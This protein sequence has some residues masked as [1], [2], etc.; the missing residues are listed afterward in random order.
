MRRAFLW[1]NH[2]VGRCAKTAS[3]ASWLYA[4][5]SLFPRSV[6]TCRFVFV[7]VNLE[8]ILIGG[9]SILLSYSY[10]KTYFVLPLMSLFGSIWILLSVI[11]REWRLLSWKDF[12]WLVSRVL[13]A[14][15]SR[16]L[17]NLLT[18]WVPLQSLKIRAYIHYFHFCF[19]SFLLPLGLFSL[20]LKNIH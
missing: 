3:L 4:H 14:Q 5:D 17:R 7:C 16:N 12:G 10:L 2:C 1:E 8:Y 20:C 11:F 9:S 19:S 6:H 15:K 13:S 18:S